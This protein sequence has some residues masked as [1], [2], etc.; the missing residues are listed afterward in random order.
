MATP[1]KVLGCS[2]PSTARHRCEKHYRRLLRREASA[3]RETCDM[4][5]CNG[6]PV[7]NGLCSDCA[8]DDDA[9]QRAVVVRMSAAEAKL[10]LHALTVSRFRALTRVR[11]VL[12]QA[13]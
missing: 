3:S 2:R 1:C 13:V 11:S 12:E 10:V 6:A 8:R 9:P 4:P 7:Q 5:L